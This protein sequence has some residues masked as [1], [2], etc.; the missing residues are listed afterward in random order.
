MKYKKGSAIVVILLILAL[1]TVG[2]VYITKKKN[3][4][5]SETNNISDMYPAVIDTSISSTS[6]NNS[7]GSTQNKPVTGGT[8][9]ITNTS[10]TQTN[11]INQN[12]A[13]NNIDSVDTQEQGD[14]EDVVDQP[15]YLISAYSQNGQNYIDVDYIQVLSGNDSL[16]AQVE[17]GQCPNVNDCYDFPNGYRRNQ[18]PLI[19]TFEVVG[20]ATININGQLLWYKVV[21]PLEATYEGSQDPYWISGNAFNDAMSTVNRNITFTEL[22]TLASEITSYFTVN[23]PFQQ[24]KTYIRIDV[25]NDKVTKIIEPYQE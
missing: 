20:S 4:T 8:T 5:T 19:R 13:S 12:S 21:P 17:D 18:N 11:T 2:G 7:S 25:Q 24:P 22:K 1:G 6:K 16:E 23:P 9:N 3:N 15:A 14:D 10:Q